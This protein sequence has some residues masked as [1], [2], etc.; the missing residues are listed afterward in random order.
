V[1]SSDLG[2]GMQSCI[3]NSIEEYKN[4]AKEWINTPQMID[5]LRQMARPQ[6]AKCA[7]MAHEERTLELEEAYFQLVNANGL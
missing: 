4:K 2:I 3:A 1:C 5:E 7:L 6:F